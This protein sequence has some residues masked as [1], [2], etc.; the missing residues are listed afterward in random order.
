[1]T[2]VAT[3]LPLAGAVTVIIP[4][5][6]EA[7]AGELSRSIKTMIFIST[8]S[9]TSLG[10][11]DSKVIEVSAQLLRLCEGASMSPVT[12]GRAAS[13]ELMPPPAGR[14]YTSMKRKRA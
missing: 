1:M 14:F 10:E 8:S 5:E 7:K 6:V 4:F 2:G 11:Q 12:I 9:V 3:E 13:A